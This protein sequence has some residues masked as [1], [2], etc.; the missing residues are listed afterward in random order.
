LRRQLHIEARAGAALEP[1]GAASQPSSRVHVLDGAGAWMAARALNARRENGR[2][3]PAVPRRH[4]GS[5]CRPCLEQVVV[6][7]VWRH[8]RLSTMRARWNWSVHPEKP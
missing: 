6:G 4:A 2:P 5:P 3:G 7:A 1:P 8:Q